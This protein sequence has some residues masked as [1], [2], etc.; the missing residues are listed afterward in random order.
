M[1]PQAEVEILKQWIDAG[2]IWP[3]G[4]DKIEIVDPLQHWSFQ[5]LKS[6]ENPELTNTTDSDQTDANWPR[7][8]IDVFVL[9]KLAEPD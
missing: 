8:M 3:D 4:I 7:S 9:Q 1:L 5:P 6:F 2:A